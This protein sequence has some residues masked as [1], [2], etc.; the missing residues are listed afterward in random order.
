MSPA[1]PLVLVP[2]DGVVPAPAPPDW[3]PPPADGVVGVG[4]AGVVAGVVAAGAWLVAAGVVAAP[5]EVAVEA[6]AAAV[7]PV[8]PALA[9]PEFVVFVFVVV[10]V[11]AA[12]PPDAPEPALMACV[13]TVNAGAP[14]VFVLV[15]VLLPQ[16]ATEAAMPSDAARTAV[17]RSAA[18]GMRRGT[19]P[20][21]YGASGAS[22]SMRLPQ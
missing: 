11:V 18:R 4:V 19:M 2:P 15:G 16:A 7:V 22:G 9:P 8:V 17:N 20:N 14:A 10:V 21:A 1:P 13:G 6:G 5:G 3:P 12:A